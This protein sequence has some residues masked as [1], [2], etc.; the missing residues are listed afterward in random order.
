MLDIEELA[1]RLEF[2][3]ED[4]TVLVELFIQN[5]EAS[6][7]DI[8]DAIEINDTEAIEQAAHAIK[9]SAGNMMLVDVQNMAGALENAARENR[10]IY[11]L[12]LFSQLEERIETL[13]EVQPSYA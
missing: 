7:A 1:K 8:E 9:G 6:L 3:I 13:Y 4:V 2:D 5:T 12:S 11:Y 10:K